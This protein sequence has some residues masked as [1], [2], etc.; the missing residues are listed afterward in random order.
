MARPANTD[1][2]ETRARILQAAATCFSASGASGASTRQI[3]Q[4][5][6]VSLATLHHHFDGKQGLYSACVDAMYEEFAGIRDELMAAVGESPAE[7]IRDAVSRSFR[8]VCAHREAVR[9]TTI[10]TIQRGR[11]EAQTRVDVLLPAIAE[12]AA[13]LAA[14]SGRDEADLRL[15]LRS[16]SY[17]VVRYA[18]TEFSE[19]ALILDEES[20]DEEALM[21][22]VS[23]HLGDL[24]LRSLGLEETS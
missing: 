11:T 15:A 16:I 13:A 20:A 9:L 17:L 14:F 2:A 21:E 7:R 22:R 8:F 18:L 4:A 10:D 5:A 12:G 6:G 24:A 3:A 19:L 1:S 23:D